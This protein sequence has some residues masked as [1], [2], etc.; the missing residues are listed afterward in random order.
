[1]TYTCL[2]FIQKNYK[3][4]IFYTQEKSTLLKGLKKIKFIEERYEDLNS[5]KGW[6]LK[7]NSYIK[8]MESRGTPFGEIYDTK[9]WEFATL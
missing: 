2:C 4:F 7:N 1:M 8:K 5:F 6:N 9:R 3:G